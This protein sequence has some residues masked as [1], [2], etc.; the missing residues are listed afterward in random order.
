MSTK[1]KKFIDKF[2]RVIIL[3]I[4]MKDKFDEQ[5]LM[6]RARGIWA[7]ITI[8]IGYLAYV[9]ISELRPKWVYSVIGIVCAFAGLLFIVWITRREK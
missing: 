9:S 6:N 4:A 2:I 8:L 1:E 3:K 7:I 5:R